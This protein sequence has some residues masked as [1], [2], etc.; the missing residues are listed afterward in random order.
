MSARIGFYCLKHLQPIRESIGSGDDRLLADILERHRLQLK[1]FYDGEEPS[2]DELADFKECAESM[3]NCDQAPDLEP[4]AWNY[5]IAPLASHFELQP[6]Q[7]PLDDWK[8]SYVLE[9]YRRLLNPELSQE[10][11]ALLTLLE[12]GRPLLGSGIDADGCSFAW[13]NPEET[14]ALHES[15][16]AI[17]PNEEME[18]LELDEFHDELLECLQMTLENGGFL[19]MAAH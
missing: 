12:N 5:V 1:E 19:F 16:S 13:L 10:S 6:V 11:Q 9:E 4:G 15:L 17:K 2:N 7:L 3:I 8:H 14:A 18:E